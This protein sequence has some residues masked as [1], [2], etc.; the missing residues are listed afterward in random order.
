MACPVLH[1]VPVR[2]HNVLL[3]DWPPGGCQRTL[4]LEIFSNRV[5]PSF[6][7]FKA[8]FLFMICPLKKTPYAQCSSCRVICI[9]F[10]FLETLDLATHVCWLMEFEWLSANLKI[11]DVVQLLT[12]VQACGTEKSLSQQRYCV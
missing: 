2:S 1:V 12:T 10:Y 5:Y 9:S 8:N 3:S 11:T 7:F 4:P 6:M